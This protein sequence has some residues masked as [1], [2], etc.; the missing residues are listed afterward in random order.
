MLLKIIYDFFSILNIFLVNFEMYRFYNKYMTNRVQIFLYFLFV[1]S[2]ETF[3]GQDLTIDTINYNNYGWQ[4]LVIENGYIQLAVFPEIGGRVLYYGFPD[5]E[6]MWINPDQSGKMYDPAT[7]LYGPWNGSSGYGGYKV[8]PAPQSAWSWPP[9]PYLAW[10]PYEYTVET[11]NADSVV[12]YLRSYQETQQAPGLQFAR[13]YKVFRNSALVK[14]DQILIN[15]NTESQIWSIW[16]VTQTVVEHEGESDYNNFSVYFPAN[17]NEITGKSN[18]S[19]SKVNENVTRFNFQYGR[20]G[21]MFSFVNKGWVSFVDERDEQ[22]YS[23]LFEIIPAIEYPDDHSNFEIYSSGGQYI[24]IEVLSPLWEVGANGD[25]VVYSEYWGAAHI[26]G[27][28]MHANALGIIK[29]PLSYNTSENRI[30][31][32]YGIFNSGSVQLK[33]FSESGEAIDSSEIITVGATENLVMNTEANLSENVNKI[34]LLCYDFN[35]NLLGVL[36]SCFVNNATSITDLP[37]GM[38]LSVYPNLIHQGEALHYRFSDF[39]DDLL[40]IE[41]YRV[42]DGKRVFFMTIR[43]CGTEGCFTPLVPGKGFYIL[44]LKSGSLNFRKKFLVE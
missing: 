21:K 6:Y 16:D 17:I 25:S 35:G 19:Y 43:Q 39:T 33:Y 38:G 20:S 14:V 4:A 40:D 42:T 11:A 24:E 26:N 12:I 44:C 28:I 15:N 27:E 37:V 7:Q 9:P 10:G 29:S 36:D 18:G 2:L 8:W 32:E 34:K 30:N 41:I 1:F 31:G 13:R 22:T 23:K 3:Y 5:D